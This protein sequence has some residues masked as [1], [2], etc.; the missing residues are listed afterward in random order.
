MFGMGLCAACIPASAGMQVDL[1]FNI[2]D[3]APDL[4]PAA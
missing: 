2:V 3:D 4:N 1:A